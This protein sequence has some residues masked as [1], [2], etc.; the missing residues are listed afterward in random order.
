MR[1]LRDC[2]GNRQCACRP[3]VRPFVRP[4]VCQRYCGL[5]IQ[6]NLRIRKRFPSA[7]H[8]FRR[9]GKV[10]FNCKGGVKITDPILLALS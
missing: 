8:T 3:S 6:C 10:E 4:F 2:V 1:R 5:E 7:V 9:F